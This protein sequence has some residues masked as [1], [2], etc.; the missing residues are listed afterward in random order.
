[1]RGGRLLEVLGSFAALAVVTSAGQ[2]AAGQ[3]V[4]GQAVAGAATT[5]GPVQIVALGHPR[6]CWQA[7]ESGAGVT[8][9][10]CDR[11][12][13][14]QQWSL[15][16]GGVVVN[17]NGYCLE[18]VAGGP[19]FTDFADQCAGVPSQI[20]HYRSGRLASAG[21]CAVAGG[22]VAPGTE[23][24]GRSC[25]GSRW[26]IGY[27]AV[28]VAPGHGRG[29]AGGT[30]GASVTVANAA[31]AQAAYGV[32]V[33]FALP[34]GVTISTLRTTQEPG[35]RCDA[36]RLT[37]TG[38]LPAGASRRITL[39]G[40]VPA[41]GRPGDSYPVRVHATVAST[42][43]RSRFSRTTASLT[44]TVAPPVTQPHSPLPL[45]AARPLHPMEWLARGQSWRRARAMSAM[46]AR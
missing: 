39:T 6:L 15:A 35:L 17:G 1:M 4:A 23:I 5:I 41:A 13:R 29:P 19:L 3:P 42:T 7:D 40:P 43:Q 36:R 8:L 46:P 45:I 18:A 10:R 11:A 14:G 22:P 44:V 20:W 16:P 34:P 12:L 30:F 28:T 27:S 25:P 37:C 32:S 24:T 26:S 31:S 9:E 2:P 38:T 33:T 21:T